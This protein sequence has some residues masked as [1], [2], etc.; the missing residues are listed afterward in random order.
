MENRKDIKI[1]VSH[2]IDLDSEIIDNPLYV[3]VRC[4]AVFDKRKNTTLLGDN[5]GD[6]ISEKRESFCEFTVLYWAWKN[7]NADYY[8]LCHYRRYIS[9]SSKRY[10]KKDNACGFI[11]EKDLNKNS[12]NKYKLLENE[13]RKQ[14]ENYDLIITPEE[15]VEQAWDGNYKSVY[16]LCENRVR[17]FDMKGVD[18]LIKIINEKYPIYSEATKAYFKGKYAKFYNCFV[19]KNTIFNSFCEFLFGVL[20]E[21]EKKLDSKNYNIWKQRMPGFMGEHLFGIFCLYLKQQKNLK[22]KV[23]DLV[24]FENTEKLKELYPAFEENNIP[25]IFGASN[26]FLSYSAVYI[27]SIID[28]MN[29]K[30]NYDIIIL[31]NNISKVNK[32]KLLTMIENKRNISIRFYNPRMLVKDRSFYVNSINQSEVA[33]YRILVPYI[34]KNYDSKAI[35]S[36][37]DLIV[38]IDIANLYKID[39]EGKIAGIVKD[40]V[41]HG[42]Y[43]GK[44][45]EIVDY[46]KNI[47]KLNNPLN[48]V[49][50]GVMLL[51]CKKY[52]DKYNIEDILNCVTQNNYMI[53]EQD[54]LNSILENNIHF[55]DLRWNLYTLSSDFIKDTVDNYASVIEKNIYYEA[56]KDPYIIHW[57]AQPKP[58]THPEIS[59]GY[60]WWEIAR[61]TPFYEEFISR[62]ALKRSEECY[63]WHR[64]KIYDLQK[65]KIRVKNIVKIF[66]PKGTRRHRFVKKLYFKLRG[67]PFVE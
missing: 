62:I 20:F 64:H 18:E 33:Y 43:N 6:N 34:L 10:M 55:L 2:R 47:L 35:V 44:V 8:G 52:R 59:L 58:W 32:E 53:Q 12:I 27:Q 39:L 67:W 38:T 50:T 51:D 49:N 22:I 57:A 9:F 7:T 54:A 19:M 66:L 3:P 26:E 31:E 46:N 41:W 36:D 29:E 25:I 45:K 60:L 37:C 16:N 13:M 40:I 28:N 30:N 24:F 42:W 48:Y 65:M 56:C 63:F 17:D 4:G 23:N 61:K 11:V 5:T 1:F 15:N 14:I 21:L